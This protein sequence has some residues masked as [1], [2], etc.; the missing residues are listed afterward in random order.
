MKLPPRRQTPR[1]ASVRQKMASN[2]SHPS[3]HVCTGGTGTGTQQHHTDSI[4]M[5]QQPAT[6]RSDPRIHGF[7]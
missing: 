4:P 2:K 5:N 6:L 3:L 1:P 7:V